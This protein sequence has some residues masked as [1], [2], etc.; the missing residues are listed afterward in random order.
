M[1]TA[2]LMCSLMKLT[3]NWYSFPLE[4]GPT[5]ML[6]PRP[7]VPFQRRFRFVIFVQLTC[8]AYLKATEFQ[9]ELTLFS[10]MSD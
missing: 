9:I 7:V 8:S 2:Q 3:D 5:Y 6:R 10:E 4:I 1:K